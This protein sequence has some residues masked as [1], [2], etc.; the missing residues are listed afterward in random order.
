MCKNRSG[1]EGRI[2]LIPDAQ[3]ALVVLISVDSILNVID[4]ASIRQHIF[5]ESIQI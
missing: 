3:W 2:K 4:S 1:Y 5:T